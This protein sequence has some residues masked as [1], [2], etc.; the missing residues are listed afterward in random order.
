[1][2]NEASLSVRTSIREADPKNLIVEEAA[3]WDAHCIFAGCNDHSIVERL[4]LGTV[5]AALISR[6]PC[7]VEV[8]R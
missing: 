1:M 5:S 2:L 7:S 4:L 8:V 6:A 3:R